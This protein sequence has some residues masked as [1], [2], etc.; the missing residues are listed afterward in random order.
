A[1]RRSSRG[2]GRGSSGRPTPGGAGSAGGT[3]RRASAGRAPRG[4]RTPRAAAPRTGRR[5]P[6]PG[7]SG[8][9]RSSGTR[10]RTPPPS[11]G[12]T[13]AP[14][15]SSGGGG[16]PSAALLGRDLRQGD[17]PRLEVELRL[18]VDL[19][20]HR[21]RPEEAV[22]PEGQGAVGHLAGGDLDLDLDRLGDD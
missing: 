4:T 7:G 12:R 18:H 17:V 11:P 21:L 13:G 16:G 14:S 2:S 10:R 19:L 3:R 1:A 5:S 6:A 20:G 15:R 22:E 9:R 8:A